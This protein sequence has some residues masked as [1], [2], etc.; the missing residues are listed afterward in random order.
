MILDRFGKLA[1]F[2][3]NQDMAAILKL[4]QLKVQWVLQKLIKQ[5]SSQKVVPLPM[6]YG[7]SSVTKKIR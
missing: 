6:I 7:G 3:S 1:I 2:P 4:L 5:G